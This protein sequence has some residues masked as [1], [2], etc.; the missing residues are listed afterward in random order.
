MYFTFTFPDFQRK[1]DAQCIVLF[2]ADYFHK[3]FPEPRSASLWLDGKYFMLKASLTMKNCIPFIDVST[4]K[5]WI[6]YRVLNTL[7][8]EMRKLGMGTAYVWF[9]IITLPSAQWITELDQAWEMEQNIRKLDVRRMIYP[10]K[11]QRESLAD[12]M[13]FS[14]FWMTLTL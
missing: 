10:R 11:P 13:F 5:Y 8:L 12:V 6:F 4:C 1:I 9:F 2:G 7:Y 3:C 14:T